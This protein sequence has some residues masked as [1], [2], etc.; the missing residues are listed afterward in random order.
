MRWSKT[1]L[2][3]SF[4]GWLA[5]PTVEPTKPRIDVPVRLEEIRQLMIRSLGDVDNAQR[6]DLA[7][8][9]S[10]A[11]DIQT[12]WYARSALMYAMSTRYGE[13]QARQQM[14]AVTRLFD[15]VVSPSL[16]SAASRKR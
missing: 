15:G 3:N 11:Q 1:T 7:C 5:P 4:L 12:L 9:L 6:A 2:R 13:R 8:H 16:S 14:E 10:L